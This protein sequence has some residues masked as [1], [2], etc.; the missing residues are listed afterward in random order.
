MTCEH[1]RH[2]DNI[3]LLAPLLLTY[4]SELLSYI[5]EDSSLRQ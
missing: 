5:L 1:V 2:P 4:S 3:L